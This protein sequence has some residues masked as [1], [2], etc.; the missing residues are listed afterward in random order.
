MWQPTFAPRKFPQSTR[1]R[2]LSEEIVAEM[3]G[4]GPIEPL[5][6]DPTVPTF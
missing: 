1:A 2:Y 3:T 5:L 4:Y 6:K